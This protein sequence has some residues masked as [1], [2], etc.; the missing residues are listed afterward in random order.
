MAAAEHTLDIDLG[1]S[2]MKF[3]CGEERG[4]IEYLEDGLIVLP[5][6]RNVERVRVSSVLG[7]EQDKSL[8]TAVLARWGCHC[9][10][11]Q[12]TPSCAGVNNGYVH[13]TALGVDRWLAVLAAFHRIAGPVLVV[14]LGT[15]VTLDYVQADGTHTGGFIVPGLQLMRQSLLRETA[16]I[17]FAAAES[18]SDLSPGTQTRDAVERGTVLSLVQLI[19]AEVERFSGLCE[20]GAGAFNSRSASVVLCGGDAP[21]VARY[22]TCDPQLVADLVLDG[23]ALA[24]P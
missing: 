9:E 23:L 4:R 10:F 21:L 18:L 13:P 12:S 24:L 17:R 1:N 19:S 3:R 2:S 8:A 15:A 11:A 6:L 7:H 22:L 20:H 14:D 5:E 16:A